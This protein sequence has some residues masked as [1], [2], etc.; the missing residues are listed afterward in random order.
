MD[1][2]N[3]IKP[4]LELSKEVAKPFEGWSPVVYKCPGGFWTIAWGH[5]CAADHPPVNETQGEV[6][7]SN[8]MM[9]ALRG[10]LK[11][12][13]DL[14]KYPQK[15]AAITDFCFNLG[16]GRLQTS[17]L[18]R[19]INAGDWDGAV[20]QIMRWNKAGCKVLRGLTLRRLVE[21]KLLGKS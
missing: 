8:D 21:A 16:V 6:Y 18:R 13:P 11:Y 5:R 1:Q 17:T 2:L 20:K 15:L 19:R 14:I 12:C 9:I 10:A 7:L 4:A 3:P